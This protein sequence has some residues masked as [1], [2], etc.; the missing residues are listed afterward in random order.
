[1]FD[2]CILD[3]TITL[4][5]LFV[6]MKIIICFLDGSL[7][8]IFNLDFLFWFELDMILWVSEILF[9]ESFEN[10]FLFLFL[11]YLELRFNKIS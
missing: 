6:L 5:V 8:V 10:I 3:C 1:M 11:F 2:I 7:V 4:S 9:V